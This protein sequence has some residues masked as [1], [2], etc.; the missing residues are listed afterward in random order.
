MNKLIFE[1]IGWYGAAAIVLA[2]FLVSFRILGAG[3]VIYQ[4]LNLSGAIGIVLVSLLKKAYQ[5]AA[6]NFIW[7]IIAL[8]A[9]IKIIF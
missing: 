9:L 5:P 7:T 2:Y 6:L 8:I 4:I 3:S 1:I